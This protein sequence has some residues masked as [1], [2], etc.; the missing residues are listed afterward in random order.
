MGVVAERNLDVG[1]AGSE[2]NAIEIGKVRDPA[3]GCPIGQSRNPE[4]ET[5]GAQLRKLAFEHRC[6]FVTRRRRRPHADRTHKCWLVARRNTRAIVGAAEI[7]GEHCCAHPLMPE[8]TIESTK[9]RC[10]KTNNTTGGSTARVAPAMTNPV[11][12]APRL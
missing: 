1:K 12:M 6:K 10:S 9:K 5:R 2:V 11:F 4:A 3:A 7:D 8:A